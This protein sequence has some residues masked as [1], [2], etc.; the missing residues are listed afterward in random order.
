MAVDNPLHRLKCPIVVAVA[1]NGH[2]ISARLV[3]AVHSEGR[4]PMVEGTGRYSENI[5]PMKGRQEVNDIASN[6]L[7]LLA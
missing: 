5:V 2:K 6:G 4:L 3:L 1:G 7:G